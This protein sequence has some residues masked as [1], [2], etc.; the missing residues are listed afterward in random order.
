MGHG[1]WQFSPELVFRVFSSSNGFCVKVVLLHEVVKGGRW[2]VVSDP[3]AVRSRVW[4]E[5]SVPTYILTIA[6]RMTD[7]PI[8]ASSPQQSDYEAVWGEPDWQPSRSKPRKPSF[9]K[10]PIA[11]LKRLARRIA[12]RPQ[13]GFSRTFFREITVDD[14]LVGRF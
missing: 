10:E 1:F 4:L 13:D 14:V 7:Q 6:Q 2:V 3:A 12:W 9:R 8:F 11:R 5:N